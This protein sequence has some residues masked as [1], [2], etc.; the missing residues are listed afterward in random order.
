MVLVLE[1]LYVRDAVLGEIPITRE[2]EE[3]IIN[4][5]EFQRLR[6]IRQL[7]LTYLVYPSAN[8]TR[9][10][11]SLGVMYT[12]GKFIDLVFE[13]SESMDLFKKIAETPLISD[14]AFIDINRIVV[15]LAGL[16]HDIGHG[17]FGH[18]FDSSVIPS[19]LPEKK[20]KVLSEKC[21]SHEVIS[22]LI[23]RYK[24]RNVIEQNL[25][26][27]KYRRYSEQIL[28]WLDQVLVPLCGQDQQL[29]MKMFKISPE[30]YGYFLRM[31]VRD[32][33]Y[34]ADLLDFLIRD[35]FYTGTIE[36]GMINKIR[37]MRNTLAI[38]KEH[39]LSSLRDESKQTLERIRKCRTPIVLAIRGSKII[40][41]IIRFLYAR[42]LMY[43][44]VYL[45]PAI[46][47][48]N[49]SAANVLHHMLPKMGFDANIIENLITNISNES[50]VE[51]FL[52]VYLGLTDDILLRIKDQV[53]KDGGI[54]SS[55]KVD[56]E[57]IFKYR[58]PKYSLLHREFIG[59]EPAL[60]SISSSKKKELENMILEDLEKSG[61]INPVASK[62][63]IKIQINTISIFPGSAWI[64]QGPF[65][66]EA[67]NG[68]VQLFDIRTF[69]SKYLLS[70]MGEVRLY[71]NRHNLEK[72]GLTSNDLSKLKLTFSKIVRS[73]KYQDELRA[74]VKPITLGT[75]TM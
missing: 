24:L 16:L 8:H 59:A 6:Y 55:I 17:P 72:S 50:H 46:M 68:D 38:P 11:H 18:L 2:I 35:S 1:K 63:L 69:S 29:Y 25:K 47:V 20:H 23:Y 19:I 36:H 12:S 37:L 22:F 43:E 44:N 48:F 41:D 75:V 15:R 4:R 56:I 21:F 58:K 30:G 40:P 13:N 49:W 28:S 26:R 42:R 10:E 5:W 73:D 32:F 27:T 52:K 45:H 71:I 70:N 31:I 57:S 66:Y 14:Q 67:I 62:S 60:I 51:E 53:M 54:D 65:I 61:V 74:V 33:L 7:Q 39:V 9:F 64:M 34:P 3:P